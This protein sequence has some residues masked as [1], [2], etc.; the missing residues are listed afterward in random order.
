MPY[1]CDTET[2]VYFYEQEFYC[3]SN[4]SA[5]RLHWCGVDFDTS[6]HAYHWSKFPEHAWLQQLIREARSAHEAFKMAELHAHLVRPGWLDIR[7]KVMWHILRAKASQHEYVRR[8]LL[9]TG[10]RLL[11]E[12]SWRDAF[13]GWG[14]DQQGLNALGGLWMTIREEYRLA[15]RN[16]T[17]TL[18]C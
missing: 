12:D 1:K 15:Q 6:E 9:E 13:W 11:I 14:A 5:F 16:G 10:E 17:G 4:F 7:L 3:L 8:K 18:G 2:T